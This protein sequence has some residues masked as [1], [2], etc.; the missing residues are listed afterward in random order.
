MMEEDVVKQSLFKQKRIIMYRRKYSK[1]SFIL[2]LLALCCSITFAQ[3]YKTIG[4]VSGLPVGAR[5][6]MFSATDQ[7]GKTYQ[8]SVELK[9][10]PVVIL[11]YRGQWCPVCNRHLSRLQDSLQQIYD[12]GAAV[13]AISPEKQELLEK[14]AAKTKATF[15]LLYDKDYAISESFDV[16]FKPEDKIVAM[17]DERLKADLAHAHSDSSARL[18]VPATFII[19]KNGVLVWRHFNPDYRVRASVHE[20]LENIPSK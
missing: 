1:T 15:T 12:K 4:A 6:P 11:F 9:K 2:T 8:L 7:H 17:Y 10:G 3:Q 19:D 13:I 18:P 20:I 5:P 14:T 16:L